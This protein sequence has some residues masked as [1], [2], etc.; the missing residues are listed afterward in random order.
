MGFYK[1]FMEVFK[2]FDWEG[3]GYIFLGEVR[4]VLIVMGKKGSMYGCNW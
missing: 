4:Y 1:E 3:Q 2:F